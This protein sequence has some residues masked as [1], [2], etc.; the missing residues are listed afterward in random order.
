MS[1]VLNVLIRHMFYVS[2]TLI[3]THVHMNEML[4]F[5]FNLNTYK[6]SIKH[7]ADAVML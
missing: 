7:I 4:P 2:P 3:H 1:F 5:K 6:A